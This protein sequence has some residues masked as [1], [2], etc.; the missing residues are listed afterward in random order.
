[1]EPLNNAEK[2]TETEQP[3]EAFTPSELASPNPLLHR[4]M[5]ARLEALLLEHEPSLFP[6]WLAK[7]EQEGMGRDAT[8]YWGQTLF[9]VAAVLPLVKRER[10]LKQGDSPVLLADRRV[11]RNRDLLVRLVLRGCK[12]R[13]EFLSPAERE[14]RLE[15]QEAVYRAR[16]GDAAY[17]RM[18]EGREQP[19]QEQQEAA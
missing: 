7:M 9:Y 2:F 15:A 18:I 1:M 4:V 14:E 13:G 17:H 8:P 10:G 11:D 5:N 6:R 19:G 12:K 3:T 16:H